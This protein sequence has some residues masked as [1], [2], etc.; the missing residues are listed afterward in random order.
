[1]KYNKVE[2]SGMEIGYRAVGQSEYVSLTDIAKYRNSEDPKFLVYTWLRQQDTLHFLCLWE[3]LNNPGFS[4]AEFDAATADSGSQSFMITPKQWI[5]KLGGVGLAIST[6]SKSKG[7]YAHEDIAFEFAS[8]I[9]PEFKLLLIKTFQNMRKTQQKEL[10]WNT[11]REL[12]KV[13]Y[14]IHTDAIKENIVP[15]LDDSQ[16]AY[17]YANE[18]DVLNVALF[19]MTAKQWRDKNP[20][21]SGNMRDFASVDQLLVLANMESYNAILIEQGAIQKERLKLLNIAARS[22]MRVLQSHNLS[23]LA[24]SNTLPLGSDEQ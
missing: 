4:R 10:E 17:V 7:I 18:A 16:L 12:A 2:V 6:G 3:E 24:G 11:K 5:E 21:K 1:M 15:T 20:D 8:W 22:Q 13:N 19:G 14:H 23:K 9:S